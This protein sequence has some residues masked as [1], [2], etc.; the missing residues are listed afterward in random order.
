MRRVTQILIGC[1]LGVQL[2]GTNVY[3]ERVEHR[4]TLGDGPV[5]LPQDIDRSVR[6]ADAVGLGALALSVG[7]ALRRRR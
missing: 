1:A 2:G 3:G 4:P 7:V 5:A 6:L